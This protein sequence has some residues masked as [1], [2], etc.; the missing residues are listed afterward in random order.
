M[1]TSDNIL[2][3]KVKA[4][5]YALIASA[6]TENGDEV[7]KTGSAEIS[8]PVVDNEGNDKFLVITLKVPK[9]SRDGE[10]YDGYGMAEDFRIKQEAKAEKKAK[11]DKAKAEKIKRDTAMREKA[12]ANREK[13]VSGS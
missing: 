12:K 13:A 3:E 9:G 8:I 1:A 4:T 6:L 7:L 2:N 5:Y 11:A 10:P